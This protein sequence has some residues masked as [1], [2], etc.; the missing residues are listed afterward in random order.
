MG[1]KPVRF[2]KGRGKALRR[3]C[4]AAALWALS[5]TQC[6]NAATRQTTATDP[7]DPDCIVA[8]VDG[9]PVTVADAWQIQ[10]LVAQPLTQPEAMRFATVVTAATMQGRAG[11]RAASARERLRAYRDLV[12]VHG[13]E[14][15]LAPLVP[16]ACWA[17]DVTAAQRG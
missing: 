4:Y 9:T 2:E 17:G 8:I 11:S 1:E 7:R 3:G 10:S 13:R 15:P 6:E 14:V 12:R 16:G 5:C